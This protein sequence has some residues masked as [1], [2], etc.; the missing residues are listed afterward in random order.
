MLIRF[1]VPKPPAAQQPDRDERGRMPAGVP[2]EQPAGHHRD[3]LG[4]E[5]DR[6]RQRRGGAAEIG[7]A[8][9]RGEDQH[10]EQDHAAQVG[11]AGDPGAAGRDEDE[12]QRDERGADRYVDQEDAAPGP[13]R[14]EGAANDRSDDAAD[15]EDAGEH[16]QRP[17]AVLAEVV[18]D[19][20][21]GRGHERTAADRLDR[22]QY[23]QGLDVGREPA[24]QRRGGE[25]DRGD[26]EDLLAAELVTD[27]PG[28]RHG[29]DLP[30]GVDGDRPAAPVDV[31]AEIVFY[32]RQSGGDD[33]LI[34]RTHEQRHRDDREDESA[35]RKGFGWRVDLGGNRGLRPHGSRCGVRRNGGRR[36]GAPC[37]GGT[38]V[39]RVSFDR[40]HARSVGVSGRS[41]ENV[42]IEPCRGHPVESILL[43]I[44][45]ISC[46]P[47]SN[48][49][50]EV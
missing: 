45:N 29:Q 37:G 6:A 3:R 19:D 16:A 4:R 15:R 47:K 18:G 9:H 25:Q 35:V 5:E 7:D 24:G 42:A 28:Q 27:L 41:M 32:R 13:G 11:A 2:E 1:M 39:D 38:A 44:C 33:R 17:V 50:A 30:E 21:G 46:L 23:H 34:D 14:D 20:P 36:N 48:Q 12:G 49:P 31:R 10:A 43:M 26:Q 22:P 8:E 40:A